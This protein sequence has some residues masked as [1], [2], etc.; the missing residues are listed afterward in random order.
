MT[1]TPELSSASTMSCTSCALNWCRLWCDPSRRQVSVRRRSR[2]SDQVR[3]SVFRSLMSGLPGEDRTGDVLTDLRRSCGHDVEVAG[4]RRQE[5]ARALDLDE[6]RDLRLALR[7]G[8]R[9]VDLWF[10]EQA[11]ARHVLLHGLLHRE[12]AGDDRV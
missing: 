12:D 6:D 3:V 5:V 2:S 8:G 4:V 9:L 7:R 1:G 11:V 10:L